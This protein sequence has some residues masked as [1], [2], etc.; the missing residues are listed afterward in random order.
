MGSFWL[1]ARNLHEDSVRVDYPRGF[2]IVEFLVVK[3]FNLKVNFRQ[4][5][6]AKRMILKLRK[7]YNLESKVWMPLVSEEA[8]RISN[9]LLETAIS[10]VFLLTNSA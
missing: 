9:P 8:F 1:P 3:T 4:S 10:L 2:L 7:A 6:L 5:L